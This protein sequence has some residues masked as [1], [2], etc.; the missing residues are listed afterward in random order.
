MR[1]WR[2]I[3]FALLAFCSLSSL[4]AQTILIDA[5][6]GAGGAI[7]PAYLDWSEVLRNQRSPDIL[8]TLD[9]SA[10]AL[11]RVGEKFFWGGDVL[12]KRSSEQLP[13]RLGFG[14]PA[15]LSARWAIPSIVFA[16]VPIQ[17]SKDGALVKFA[18]G[19]GALFGSI[20]ETARLN[21]DVLYSA[22]GFAALSELAFG[23]PLNEFFVATLNASLRAGLTGKAKT[24]SQILDEDA[25]TLSF[26]S[27][28]LCIGI[29][30]KL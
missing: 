17:P 20:R 5:K 12:Y 2:K 8:Q 19:A 3:A 15:E 7:A 1:E 21:R 11:Y 13:S 26:V 10:S 18:F 28:A 24:K 29:V 6:A 22:T 4:S 27:F 16:F 25:P 30:F 23:L 9:V 14:L